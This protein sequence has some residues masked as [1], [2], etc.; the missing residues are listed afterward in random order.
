MIFGIE[1]KKKK[2]K[3]KKKTIILRATHVGW[4]VGHSYLGHRPKCRFKLNV[5][6][7]LS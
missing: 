2:K 6:K 5:P 3:K 4:G 7:S 1:R